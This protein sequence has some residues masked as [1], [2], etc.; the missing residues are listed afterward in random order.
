MTKQANEGVGSTGNRKQAVS[1]LR[2]FRS[3]PSSNRVVLRGGRPMVRKG[4]G[5]KDHRWSGWGRVKGEDRQKLRLKRDA[6]LY[7]LP[8]KQGALHLCHGCGLW[9]ASVRGRGSAGS[10]EVEVSPLTACR[11][12]R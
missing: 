1:S 2:V 12:V 3:K 6:C 11:F 4:E 8:Q 10:S 9:T 5:G 7:Q